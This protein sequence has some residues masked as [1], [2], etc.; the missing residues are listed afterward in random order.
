[1]DHAQRAIADNDLYDLIVETTVRLKA[2]RFPFE[3]KD[4]A[5]LSFASEVAR[6]AGFRRFPFWVYPESHLERGTVLAG[7]DDPRTTI[8]DPRCYTARTRALLWSCARNGHPGGL[9]HRCGERGSFA[10]R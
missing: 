6:K 4:R 5:F 2:G 3:P 10:G 9:H 7:V 1:M 8:E